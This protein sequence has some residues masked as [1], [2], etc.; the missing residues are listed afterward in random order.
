MTTNPLRN[1]NRLKLGV[2]GINS[3]YIAR[4]LPPEK[5]QL[6]WQNS[7]DVAEVADQLGLEAIV[8]LARFRSF[9]DA[10]HHSGHAFECFSWSAAVAARTKYSAVMTT[11][12]VMNIHPV[13]AAKALTTIDHISEGRLALNIVCGWFREEA[14]MF[15]LT[16]SDRDTGYEYADEWISCIKRLWTEDDEFDFDGRHIHIKRGMSQPKPIQ[17]P[18][19]ML[20]NAGVSSGAQQFVARH[21]DIAFIRANHISDLAPRIAAYRKVRSTSSS[22]TRNMPIGL[23]LMPISRNEANC[24]R[25]ST[26]PNSSGNMHSRVGACR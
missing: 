12:P 22:I 6:T 8:P 1:E 10:Q 2:F 24:R 16:L 14:E 5:Y 19:P 9:S 3:D 7:L 13:Y 25:R 20:M 26:R 11:I 15:G 18:G 23:T 21:C 17:A 4:T